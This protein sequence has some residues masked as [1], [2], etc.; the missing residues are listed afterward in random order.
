MFGQ[1]SSAIALPEVLS[2]PAVRGEISDVPI[3]TAI[4]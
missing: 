4:R 1:R 3:H 2:I